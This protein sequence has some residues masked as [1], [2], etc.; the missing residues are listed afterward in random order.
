MKQT[1]MSF[2]CSKVNKSCGMTL[3]I[4]VEIEGVV[5]GVFRD[6]GNGD[7]KPTSLGIKIEFINDYIKPLYRGILDSTIAID[8]P[9]LETCIHNWYNMCRLRTDSDEKWK[10]L[11]DFADLCEEA[12]GGITDWQ[13]F[14]DPDGEEDEELEF[15]YTTF[16]DMPEVSA[17]QKQIYQPHLPFMNWLWEH[18]SFDPTVEALILAAEEDSIL[19]E[20]EDGEE[21]SSL[22]EEEDGEEDDEEAFFLDEVD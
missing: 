5:Y 12:D 7:R 6:K 9:A 1:K 8:N 11:S 4:G 18:Y 3:S 14:Q 10:D 2:F 19:D 17:G 21:A 13:K 16:Y 15:D 22:N 20:N